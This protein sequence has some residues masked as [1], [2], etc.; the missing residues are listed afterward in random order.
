[1]CAWGHQKWFQIQR[2]FTELPQECW[3]LRSDPLK[4]QWVPCKHHFFNIFA[5]NPE[6]RVEEKPPQV[7]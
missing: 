7:R 6:R 4:E 1:M 5:V 3:D 2:K